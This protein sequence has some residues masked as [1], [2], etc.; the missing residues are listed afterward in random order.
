MTTNEM[1]RKKAEH[2]YKIHQMEQDRLKQ[3]PKST[4]N[5]IKKEVFFAE[6]LT[7]KEFLIL[8]LKH[9]IAVPFII[10]GTWLLFATLH[11]LTGVR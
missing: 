9:V 11:A 2:A 8:T 4:W 1:L 5:W 3:K 10:A 7:N 6:E